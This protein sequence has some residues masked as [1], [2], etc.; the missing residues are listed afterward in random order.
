MKELETWSK[1]N[2]NPAV[3]ES[4]PLKHHSWSY[5]TFT[6]DI[7]GVKTDIAV[8]QK[9][10]T[11]TNNVINS[12]NAIIES[13]GKVLDSTENRQTS[14]E[15]CR[16]ETLLKEFSIILDEKNRAINQQDITIK[17][18]QIIC[19]KLKEINSLKFKNLSTKH[20]D[21]KSKTASPP[22]QP[23]MSQMNNIESSFAKRLTADR[24]N[25]QGEAIHADYPLEKIIIC[26]AKPK[27]NTKHK[28]QR[29]AQ[30]RDRDELLCPN[31]EC[32]QNKARSE[33]V[34][35]VCPSNVTPDEEKQYQ[36][37]KPQQ[38]ENLYMKPKNWISYLRLLETPIH[39]NVQVNNSDSVFQNDQIEPQSSKSPTKPPLDIKYTSSGK[40][41]IERKR[42]LKSE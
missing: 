8:M 17:L 9:Q 25:D 32:Q 34:G 19:L 1:S 5:N 38:S 26:K 22:T 12:T 23:L 13:I 15:T 42:G 18:L 37:T 11:S 20:A 35:V 14:H 40:P 28:G 10:I 27:P 6:K 36:Q 21:N 29:Q 30:T 24:N 31:N 16:M 41:S 3:A 39:K 2:N 33:A 7:K 4:T